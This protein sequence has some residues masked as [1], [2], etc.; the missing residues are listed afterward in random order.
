[1]GSEEQN[2]WKYGQ[3]TPPEYDI[4]NIKIPVGVFSGTKDP[5]ADPKDVEWFRDKLGE[6]MIFWGEY[7]FNH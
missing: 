7:E 6:K 5:L 3:T 2:V 4:N 1:M